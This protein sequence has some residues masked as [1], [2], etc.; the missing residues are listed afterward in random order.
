[1]VAIVMWFGKQVSRSKMG[2]T[3]MWT[4]HPGGMFV[5]P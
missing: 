5:I 1:M 3:S 2:I 4:G